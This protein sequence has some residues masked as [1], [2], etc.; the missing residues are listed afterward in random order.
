MIF[1][2][3]LTSFSIIILLD[4]NYEMFNLNYFDT[5]A[6]EEISKKNSGDLN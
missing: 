3:L 1:K 6:F 5:A 4:I 2:F